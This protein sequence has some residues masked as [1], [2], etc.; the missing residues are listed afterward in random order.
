MLNLLKSLCLI[1]GTAGDETAVRDFI[2]N[3]IKDFC[4]YKIDNLGNI[5]CFK[6]GEK[7]HEIC[8][9]ISKFALWKYRKE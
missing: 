1:D 7:P 5:I 3:E 8:S 2:I 6:K 9:K 4:E